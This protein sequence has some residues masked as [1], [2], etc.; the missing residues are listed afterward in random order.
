MAYAS[1][2]TSYSNQGETSLAT[3][4]AQKAYEMRD[5]VTERERFHIESNYYFSVTHDLEKAREVSEIWR[6]TYPEDDVPA[7]RLGAIYTLLGQYD[8]ALAA[9]RE[10][11]RLAPHESLSYATVVLAY[12]YLNRLEEARVTAENAAANNFDS[13]FLHFYLYV[14]AFLHD[15]P[16]GMAQQANWATGKPGVE[17]VL[18][19]NEADTAA[20]TGKL[21]EARKLSRRA[22]ASATG[23]EEIEPAAAYEAEAAIRESLFGNSGEARQWTQAAL[24][25]STSRDIEYA[26]AL[27][28]GIGTGTVQSQV[29]VKKL[30]DDL[31]K[32]YPEDT[33]VRFNYLPTLRALLALKRDNFST[34][35]E[36][37]QVAVPYELGVPS[38]GS[39]ALY[40]VYVRGEL[41]LAAH[42]GIEAAAEFQRILDHSGVVNNEPI[43]ALARLGLARAYGL[44]GD[45]SKARAAYENFLTLWKDA[46]PH[47]PVLIAAKAEYA[48]LK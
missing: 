48:K 26:T 35:L 14:L 20:Y 16:A 44:Q 4:N 2:G 32:R 1:L 5:R 7:D 17:D 9:T 42:N 36:V 29:Q 21:G 10:S 31:A 40:P 38:S 39:T 22:V 45:I 30:A 41:F 47:I 23:A 25:R 19:N 3:E 27:A 43:G 46:D 6:R 8:K 33:L 37:L 18:L 12:I 13:P 11:V 34:S 28:L 15:D 24:A